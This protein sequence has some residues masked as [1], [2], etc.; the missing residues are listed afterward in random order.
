MSDIVTEN[1]VRNSLLGHFDNFLPIDRHQLGLWH[2]KA[3]LLGS[4]P[5]VGS[6]TVT[7]LFTHLSEVLTLGRRQITALVGA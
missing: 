4:V 5:A 2:E 3:R 6:V 7:T 1:L